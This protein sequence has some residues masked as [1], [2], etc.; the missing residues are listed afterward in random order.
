MA[1]IPRSTTSA[2]M[3][4]NR[5]L[6][7][8]RTDGYTLTIRA[9]GFNGTADIILAAE[10]RKK[11]FDRLGGGRQCEGTSDRLNFT[12][13]RV[14]R[15]AANAN[16]RPFFTGHTIVGNF[17]SIRAAISVIAVMAS[18]VIAGWPVVL[19]IAFF[20]YGERGRQLDGLTSVFL[21][22]LNLTKNP[23]ARASQQI[24]RLGRIGIHLLSS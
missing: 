3:P 5:C 20:L 1:S 15:P 10:R 8:A 6:Y 16:D 17:D 24:G 14:T 18:L 19:A 12:A 23:P 22:A 13:N 4:A 21:P 7:G 2:S 11:T 9:A